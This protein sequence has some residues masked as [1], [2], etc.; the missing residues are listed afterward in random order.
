M[1][2]QN[3]TTPM[4]VLQFFHDSNI[5]DAFPHTWVAL[6][7]FLALSVMVASGERSFSKLKLIKTY[8]RATTGYDRLNSLAILSIENELAHSLDVSDVI[9]Q[10]AEKKARREFMDLVCSYYIFI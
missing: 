8:L 2:P 5:Y 4:K 1:L 6:R 3:I 9:K 7:I 10:F